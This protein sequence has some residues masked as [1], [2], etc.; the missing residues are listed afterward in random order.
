MIKIIATELVVATRNQDKLKEIK[1]FLKDL[2]VRVVSLNNFK[3]APEVK[4]DKKTLE[5]NAKKKAIEYSRFLKK[6]VVAD[7]SGLE[8][9]ALGNQPGVYSARFSGKGATYVSNNEKLL[10]LLKDVPSGKRQ[11]RF[12]CVIAV[13]DNGKVIGVAEGRCN[14]KIGFEPLGKTGFGYDPIFVPYGHKKTF[15]QL[16]MEKKNKISHRSKALIRSKDIIKKYLA[17]TF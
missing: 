14:G 13:A 9:R 17:L 6:L 16:G 5:A 12:R 1:A 15:A 11:A 8:V 7:D 2:P 3:G 4:E 10:R